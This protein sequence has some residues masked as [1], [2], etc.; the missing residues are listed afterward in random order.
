MDKQKEKFEELFDLWVDVAHKE[1]VKN[2]GSLMAG[3]MKPA[4]LAMKDVNNNFFDEGVGFAQKVAVPDGFVLVP[5]DTI[6]AVYSTCDLALESEAVYRS[7]LIDVRD[8]LFEFAEKIDAQ[9][10]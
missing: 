8:A 2:L 6:V 1:N 10:G 5:N 9:G 3:A 4:L 7:A